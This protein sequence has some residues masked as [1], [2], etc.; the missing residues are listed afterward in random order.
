M[1]GS[2]LQRDPLKIT[3]FYNGNPFARGFEHKV[4]KGPNLALRCD[5]KI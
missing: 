4:L 3:F 2:P 5:L 1:R